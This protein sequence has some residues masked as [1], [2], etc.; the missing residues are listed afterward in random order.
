M[1][2]GEGGISCESGGLKCPG[3]TGVFFNSNFRNM[4][5]VLFFLRRDKNVIFG[6]EKYHLAFWERQQQLVNSGNEG[7]KGGF[8]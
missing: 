5:N 2:R 8:A 6:T 4:G 7:M 3:K 1:T